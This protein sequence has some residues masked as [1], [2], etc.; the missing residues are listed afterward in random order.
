MIIPVCRSLENVYMYNWI[1]NSPLFGRGM[2]VNK[3]TW[4]SITLVNKESYVSEAVSAK[5]FVEFMYLVFTCMSGESYVGDSG[6][7]DSRFPPFCLGTP[8][9]LLVGCLTLC[10]SHLAY[11][12]QC[13][14]LLNLFGLAV[15]H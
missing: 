5:R 10:L 9:S 11:N 13:Y 14:L 2:D 1:E 7:C 15:R 8:L 12:C 3:H 4:L 6:L